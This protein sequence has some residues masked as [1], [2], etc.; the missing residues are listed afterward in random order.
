MKKNKI[1]I[2][3]IIKIFI[4][5]HPINSID[6]GLKNIRVYPQFQAITYPESLF[7]TYP[8]ATLFGLSS[9]LRFLPNFDI[10]LG[11]AFQ[12]F[13]ESY[14]ITDWKYFSTGFEYQLFGDKIQ[15]FHFYPRFGVHVDYY[16][17]KGMNS[18]LSPD[19]QIQ[20]KDISSLGFSISSGIDLYFPRKIFLIPEFSVGYILKMPE[21]AAKDKNG[22]L[23]FKYKISLGR[24]ISIGRSD[25]SMLLQDEK[26]KVKKIKLTLKDGQKYEADLIELND[27]F[28]IIFSEEFGELTLKRKDI[29]QIDTNY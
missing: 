8:M 4:F 24:H 20:T 22:G 7:N 1:K 17:M 12:S 5:I 6:F 21:Y 27:E 18:K 16:I 26:G 3:F 9:S 11:A 19:V 23:I 10:S 25:S 14:I 28:I 29:K 2:I 15:E 13:H